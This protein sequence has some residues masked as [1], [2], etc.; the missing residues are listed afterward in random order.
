MNTQETTTGN[1][2]ETSKGYREIVEVFMGYADGYLPETISWNDVMPVVEKIYLSGAGSY[3]I[4]YGCMTITGE[5]EQPP[6]IFKSENTT[7]KAVWFAIVDFIQWYN[8]NKT[9]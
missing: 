5:H 3:T 4:S 6:N 7:I 2:R 1:R 9:T 8:Q